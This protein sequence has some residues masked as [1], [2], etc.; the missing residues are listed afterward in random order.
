V[1]G[2]VGRMTIA[3][4]MANTVLAAKRAAGV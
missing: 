3:M 4:L 2:G 1:P